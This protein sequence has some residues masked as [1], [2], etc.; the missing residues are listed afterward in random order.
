LQILSDLG[1]EFRKS[2]V[3]G[4]QSAIVPADCHSLSIGKDAFEVA[5]ENFSIHIA[6]Q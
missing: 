5:D 2:A 4:P 1:E 6:P 3:R